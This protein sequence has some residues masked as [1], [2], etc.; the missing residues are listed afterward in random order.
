MAFVDKELV[1]RYEIISKNSKDEVKNVAKKLMSL[2]NVLVLYLQ[3]GF[4]FYNPYTLKL[5]FNHGE[6]REGKK[7]E[8]SYTYNIYETIN[9]NNNGV[10]KI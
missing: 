2:N 7:Y 1:Y 10:E 3:M 4:D 9:N 6:K 8:T 5:E